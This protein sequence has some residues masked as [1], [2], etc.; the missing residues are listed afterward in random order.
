MKYFHIPQ[1][2]WI[3][4]FGHFG[5]SPGNVERRPWETRFIRY[6]CLAKDETRPWKSFPRFSRR[7]RR[8]WEGR[9]KRLRRDAWKI[10]EERNGREKSVSGLKLV[11]AW[12]SSLQLFSFRGLGPRDGKGRKAARWKIDENANGGASNNAERWNEL[13]TARRR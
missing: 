7:A 6:T 12:L 1:K 3:G 2:Y 5:S 9:T 8:G 13:F 11:P 10:Q 4:H